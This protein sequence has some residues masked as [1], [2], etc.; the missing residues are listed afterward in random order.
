MLLYDDLSQVWVAK[1]PVGLQPAEACYGK[2]APEAI[3]RAAARALGLDEG[4]AGA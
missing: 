2:T 4:S 3:V 1:F